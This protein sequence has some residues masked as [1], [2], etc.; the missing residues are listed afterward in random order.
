MSSKA[1]GIEVDRMGWDG[2]G[3]L[4]AVSRQTP[5][6]I[7]LS[8][9]RHRGERRGEGGEGK[10]S[11]RDNLARLSLARRTKGGRWPFREGTLAQLLRLLRIPRHT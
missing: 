5:N 11:A 3:D 9:H 1:G 10:E 6:Q 4:N 8:I 2:G 7:S